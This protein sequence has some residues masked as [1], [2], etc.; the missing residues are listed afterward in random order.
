M[1]VGGGR[2]DHHVDAAFDH[3]PV[4]VEAHE[5]VIIVDGH[6]P[7]FGLLESRAAS[8]GHV[9]EDV[10]HGGKP[11]VVTGIHGIVG[12]AGAAS[13]AADQTDFQH[14]AP[15][16]VGTSGDGQ[17]G[18]RRRAHGRG[19]GLQEVTS[20][21]LTKGGAIRSRCLGCLLQTGI[22]ARVSTLISN[23]GISIRQAITEDPELS[24]E[25][26]LT[27]I[28]EEEIPAK[29]IPKIKKAKGVGRVIIY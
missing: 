3:F 9:V 21:C 17:A 2:D 12:R 24:D 6:L 28:C 20:R 8:L 4:G 26:T 1:E 22:L 16:G 19:G 25:A 13:A 5:D 18:D 11:D 27:I 23:E 7:A 15:G 29:L 10:G 14:V